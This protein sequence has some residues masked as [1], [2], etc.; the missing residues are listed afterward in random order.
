MIIT[1]DREFGSGGR[2]LGRHLARELGFAYYDREILEEI[3]KKT[4]YCMEYIE[5]V[6]ESKPI[7]LFPIH[8]AQTLSFGYDVSMQQQIEILEIQ[9]DTLIELAEK[10]PCVI[11]GR[12]GDFILKN[13][14]PFRIFVYADDEMKLKRY[15]E[16]GDEGETDKA[17]LKKI[18]EIDKR[19]RKY[20]EFFTGQQWGSRRNYDLLVNSSGVDLKELASALA[21]FIR[22]KA[23]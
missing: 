14:N 17:I 19:R 6:S 7:S 1:L 5:S 16:H 2:E 9:R 21:T 10:S 13:M 18:G 15:R 3:A 12:A 4:D 11:I 20:Y 23:Q 8:H 22:N